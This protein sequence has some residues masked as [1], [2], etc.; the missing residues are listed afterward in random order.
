MTR[1]NGLNL[2]DLD[3]ESAQL[4]LSVGTAA[5]V[6]VP[7]EIMPRQIPSAIKPGVARRAKGIWNEFFGG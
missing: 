6:K 4:D 2:G 5:E 3:A 1:E 7:C